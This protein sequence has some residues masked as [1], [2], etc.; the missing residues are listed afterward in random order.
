MIFCVYKY[1][2]IKTNM[3]LFKC[4]G[5]E[6]CKIAIKQPRKILANYTCVITALATPKLLAVEITAAKI[7]NGSNLKLNQSP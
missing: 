3:N 7:M 6:F 5:V 2:P 4:K 1:S